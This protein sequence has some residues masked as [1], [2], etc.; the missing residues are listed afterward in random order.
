MSKVFENQAVLGIAQSAWMVV[1]RWD[2][3]LLLVML[4]VF[5]LHHSLIHLIF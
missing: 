4:Q 5:S 1:K 2:S 3:I